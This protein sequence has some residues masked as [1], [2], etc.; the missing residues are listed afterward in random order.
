MKKLPL[1]L[2]VHRYTIF[3]V[4]FMWTLDKFVNPAHGVRVYEHFYFLGGMTE[5]IMMFIG[6]AEMALLFLFLAGV[7]KFWT[8]GAVLV[9]HGVSTF[10]A[11]A[12]YFDPWS[13]ANL[14][15]FAAWPMF[16]ACLMLFFMRDQDT[17]FTIKRIS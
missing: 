8:Y 10:S 3:L 11:L 17:M 14:L 5:Q 9:F 12:N 1:L 16:A 4:M 6:V 7:K 2:L 13:G 15:F